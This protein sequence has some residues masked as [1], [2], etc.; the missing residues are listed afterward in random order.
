MWGK[1]QG[2]VFLY[3][4]YFLDYERTGGVTLSSDLVGRPVIP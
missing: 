4:N 1:H 3:N 2:K